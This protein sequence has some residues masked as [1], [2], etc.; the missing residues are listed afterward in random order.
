MVGKALTRHCQNAGDEVLGCDRQVLD[1]TDREITHQVVSNFRPDAVIN[2]AAWTDVDG[3]ESDPV[4]AEAVNATGPENLALASRAVDAAFVTVSTDYVF[5][6]EKEGFYT[7]RDQPRPQGVYANS[8]LNGERRSALAYARSIVVRS[9][10]IFGPGGKNYLSTFVNLAKRGT[11]LKAIT[12]SFGTPTYALDLAKSLR[13]LATLDIPGTY[14]VVNAGP[15]ASYFEIV[16][17]GLKDANL[18]VEI[19]RVSMHSLQRPAPRPRNS[20]LRCLLS[21]KIGLTPMRF[22]RDALNDFVKSQL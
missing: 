16:A 6:G 7:Q 14:H 11:P 21:D 2:C 17:A 12:D 10:F 3:C 13:E 5:D 20:R 15:G 19:E 4:R 22:W 18:A 8:K 1:I 9:G